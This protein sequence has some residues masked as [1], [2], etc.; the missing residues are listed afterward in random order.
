MAKRLYTISKASLKRA[1]YA[2]LVFFICPVVVF[3]QKDFLNFKVLDEKTKEPIQFC[4]VLVKGKNVSSQS[5][6]RGAV[7]IVARPADTLVIYQLGYFV[8]K[9]TLSEIISN[10]YVITIRSKNITLDEVIIKP[11][12]TD[13]F[14]NDNTIFFLDFELY[15][16]L[17]L[18]LVSRGG[19]YN[20]LMLLNQQ[21]NKVAEKR[22]TVKSEAMFKDCFNAIH[23]LTDDSIY[24]VYY[25]YQAIKLLKPYS[26]KNYYSVLKPCECYYGNKFMLKVKKYQG[27]KTFYYMVDQQTRQ[28]PAVVAV[29]ADSSAIRGF[30]MDYDLRYFLDIRRGG[31]GYLTSVTELVKHLDELREDLKL[32][33]EYKMVLQDMQSEMKLVDTNFILVDYTNKELYTLSLNGAQTNKIKLMDF[34]GITPKLTIDHDTR[35][36]VFSRLSVTGT[37]TLYRYDLLRNNFT[38]KFEL[39]NFYY[40][41]K[42]RIKENNLYFINKDRSETMSKV[43]II[44][45]FINWQPITTPY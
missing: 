36:L 37:L 15:D 21:G 22:L 39:R 24:Q 19:R 6:E 8:K 2:I 35:N 26:I 33:P 44:K 17:I 11:A 7:K 25:D 1:V 40:V 9:T 14:Q 23:I 34:N 28:K 12:K 30:N 5:N 18:A 38:H 4:Y 45:E 13:T 3:S 43:K 42:F 10:G 29:V 41:K 16:D 20:S 27:L 31:G 32:P